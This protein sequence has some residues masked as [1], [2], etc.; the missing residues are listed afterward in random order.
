MEKLLKL[1]SKTE[2]GR[3]SE[4]LLNVILIFSIIMLSIIDCMVLYHSQRLGA[5]YNGIG[6]FK[7][8]SI[9]AAFVFLYYL[10][11]IGRIKIASYSL[12][13][14]YFVATS[15]GS[16]YLGVSLPAILLTYALIIT[17]ASILIDSRFGFIVSIATL[18]V[19]IAIGSHEMTLIDRAVWKNQPLVYGDIIAYG[20]LLVM[21]TVISWL[22]NRETEKSLRRA[23]R[24]EEELTIERDSLE[25]KVD[26]RTRELKQAHLEKVTQLSRF[27]EF[28]KLSSGLFH[29]LMSP[30][31]SI[32][33]N[34]ND[35]DNS[36]HPDVMGVK[37]QLGNAVK[38]SQRMD[39]FL[40]SIRKQIRAD[41]F[42]ETFCIN[43]IIE[44]AIGLFN[45]KAIKAK[46]EIIFESTGKI[47]TYGN[48]IK[49]HQIISNLV[50]NAI[51]AYEN[52]THTPKRQV[53]ISLNT[54]KDSVEIKVTDY[55]S[56]ISTDILPKI[57]DQFFTTKPHDKGTGLG[58]YMTK[59]ITEKEFSG[60]IDVNS[61]KNSES[62][63]GTTFTVNIPIKNAPDHKSKHLDSNIQ[64]NV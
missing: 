26:Q 49:F 14:I 5:K 17:I 55:G 2:D 48:P 33:L 1:R 62:N 7:M 31:S 63:S 39:K 8:S 20:L 9:V 51:D 25:I 16:Y 6:V 4:L 35:V 56:G 57:F 59:E 32:S 21:I 47:S 28:G 54:E 44:E 45:H 43:D 24:S 34:I 52:A 50:S 58:L 41:E 61:S 23:R 18:I 36:V 30:L 22:S 60:K 10:S 53:D 27:A 11:R 64:S 15:I 19:M 38:A 42:Y 46:I 29:D 13:A 12:V 3:R 40:S 37:E